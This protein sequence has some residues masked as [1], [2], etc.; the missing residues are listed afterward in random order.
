M[1][2]T[3]L[4]RSW[5]YGATKTMA[6]S[7]RIALMRFAPAHPTEPRHACFP[8][9]QD[10]PVGLLSARRPCPPAV[11][12]QNPAICRTVHR[13]LDHVGGCDG[14]H[15]AL[16]YGGNGTRRRHA[17][18]LCRMARRHCHARG[19]RRLAGQLRRGTPARRVGGR[20]R[21]RPLRSGRREG[22]CP[23][24][25]TH[26]RGLPRPAADQRGIWRSALPGLADPASGRATA[27]QR[28]H[29]RPAF[30]RHPHRARHASGTALP[31]QTAR[32]RQQHPPPGHQAGG[33]G[34]CRRSPQRTR[35]RSRSDPAASGARAR[36]HRRHTVAPRVSPGWL[37]HP[38]RHRHP[39]RF[40]GGLQRR[41]GAPCRSRPWPAG[42]PPGCGCARDC[43]QAA[44]KSCR[45]AVSSSTCVAPL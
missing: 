43:S 17:G 41:Q 19:C 2:G 25:Q 10:R 7:P 23:G 30:P 28:H 21:A 38:G 13:P 31:R 44:R 42:R 27:P 11:H 4:Q 35:R 37:G 34:F 12:G 8:P 3:F 45:M 32:A 39:Q 33:A 36:L 14:G 18:P 15:G 20:P 29:L 9:P 1:H 40:S 24:R 22:V 16:P 5:G 6:R 26:F